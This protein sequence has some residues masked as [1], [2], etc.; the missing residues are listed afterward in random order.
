MTTEQVQ[1][2]QAN[3]KI[4][5]GDADYD[6]DLETDWETYIY[7]VKK[8]YGLHLGPPLT[9]T[10]VCD[11]E[12][13]AWSELDR[14]LDIWAKQVQSGKP[15]TRAQRLEIFGGPNGRNR[16]ALEKFFDEAKKR[17]IDR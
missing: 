2:V 11:S 7:V 12:K 16:L 5:W 10:G 9:M 4:I 15:M 17:G 8:D 13:Q 1:K 6:L 3:C 14:M